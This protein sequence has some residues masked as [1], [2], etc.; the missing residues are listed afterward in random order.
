MAQAP[1]LAFSIL[2]FRVKG[3]ANTKV[4]LALFLSCTLYLLG[5]SMMSDA[6][7]VGSV[8]RSPK[9]YMQAYLDLVT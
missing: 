7:R 8:P 4:S 2:G 9:F 1:A 3:L 5:L 6:L